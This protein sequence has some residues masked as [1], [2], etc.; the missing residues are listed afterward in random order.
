MERNRQEIKGW[1]NIDA[2][3]VEEA[4]RLSHET[5]KILIPT[6][7]RK[8]GC[9]F[10]ATWNP[11][12]RHDWIWQRFVQ[13]PRDEDV[14][15]KV[16]WHLNPWFPEALDEERLD[17][18]KN[19]PELYNHIWEGEPDDEGAARKVLPYKMLD[20][21]VD[22]H[23]AGLHKTADGLRECGLDIADGGQDNNAMCVRHG[24]TILHAEDWHSATPGDLKPTAMRA[25]GVANDH[26]ASRVYYDAGGV[27][28][29]IRGEFTRIEGRRF[30]IRPVLFGEKVKNEKLEYSPRA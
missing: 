6:I 1:E 30:S 4:Q 24:P 25:D 22:A 10:W 28:A 18:L 11:G 15:L 9:E 29:P 21:C 8:E 19:Y 17:D 14:T 13:H 2:I 7:F 3:W 26:A 16:D 23:R 20:L 27:G 12:E 5:A